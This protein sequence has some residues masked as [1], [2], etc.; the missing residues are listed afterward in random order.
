MN[1]NEWNQQCRAVYL[2]EQRSKRK[3]IYYANQLKSR[4]AGIDMGIGS[5]DTYLYLDLIKDID[6]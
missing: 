1:R 5:R 2:K 3:D 4:L 6:R